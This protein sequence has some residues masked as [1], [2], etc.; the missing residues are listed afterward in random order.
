MRPTRLLCI[1][2][3]QG[4]GAWLCRQRSRDNNAG[5]A[6]VC[7][8]D[9]QPGGATMKADPTGSLDYFESKGEGGG[10]GGGGGG[11]DAEF[12]TKLK[13]VSSAEEFQQAINGG[14]PVLV[15]FYAPWCG[16]CRQIAPFI[17][18]L[19]AR[20]LP[21][22]HYSAG[23]LHARQAFKATASV[24]MPCRSRTFVMGLLCSCLHEH[25]DS[26]GGSQNRV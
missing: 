17:E 9:W 14:H 1:S 12:G 18:Q 24:G 26:M 7:P 25:A 10:G 13:S 11:E 5:D 8:A 20:P 16:K 21:R 4:R 15:D 3:Q 2:E 6:Q 23:I 22:S 19:Q